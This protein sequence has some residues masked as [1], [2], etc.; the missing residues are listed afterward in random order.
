LGHSLKNKN[1]EIKLQ[2]FLRKNSQI[3]IREK[4]LKQLNNFSAMSADAEST[5]KLNS[6]CVYGFILK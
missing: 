5:E 4:S 1:Y 6:I 2:Q 3:T